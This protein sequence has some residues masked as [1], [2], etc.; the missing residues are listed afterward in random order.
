MEPAYELEVQAL[1]GVCDSS[2]GAMEHLTD[3]L[4][5]VEPVGQMMSG[6]ASSAALHLRA[7]SALQPCKG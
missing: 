7:A 6:V 2:D 1:S 4:A 3:F 5:C